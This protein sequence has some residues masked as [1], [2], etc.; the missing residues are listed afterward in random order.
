MSSILIY[1]QKLEGVKLGCSDFLNSHFYLTIMFN[2][3]LLKSFA[4]KKKNLVFLGSFFETFTSIYF[5]EADFFSIVHR[6]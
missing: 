2:D 5:Y 1:L 4:M 6:L 3:N